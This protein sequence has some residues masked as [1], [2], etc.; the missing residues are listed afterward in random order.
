MLVAGTYIFESTTDDE[1]RLTEGRL[2][3][4]ENETNLIKLAQCQKSEGFATAE[5]VRSKASNDRTGTKDAFHEFI[6]NGTN[7]YYLYRLYYFTAVSEKSTFCKET[8]PL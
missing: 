8:N 3:F 6:V 2:L 4:T 1:D 5:Q 7:K